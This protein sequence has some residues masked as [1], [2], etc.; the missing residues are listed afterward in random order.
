MTILGPRRTRPELLDRERHDPEELA[1]SL[2]QVA[3]V[4]RWLGGIRP[5]REQLAPLRGRAGVRILDVGTGNAEVL[6]DL[7]RRVED[8]DDP[9]WRGVGVDIHPQML[10]AARRADGEG[11]HEP[12]LVRGDALELPFADASFDAV[13][14]TLTLHHF[15][16]GEAVR[17]VREMARVSRR[18]VLVN[19]LERSLPNYLGARV[20]AA[21]WWR[22]NRLTRNDGPL[23]V[24]RSFTADELHDVGERAG[25]DGPRVRRVMP[26]R[27][28]LVGQ[29]S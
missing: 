19:D 14:C 7:L 6:R 10:T 28:V 9:G 25:L 24:L 18:L 20:L 13:L 12:A 2:D 17:L 22:G 5:L 21:T 16:D 29:T 27:L 15:P 26:F 3:K 23:S 1:E 11:S 4:N 8:R